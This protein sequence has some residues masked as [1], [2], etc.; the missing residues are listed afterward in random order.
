MH[1]RSSESNQTLSTA[2]TA[3]TPAVAETSAASGPQN[4]EAVFSA[5]VKEQVDA[6]GDVEA[7]KRF[8]IR[9]NQHRK[10]LE[11]HAG[12]ASEEKA[13]KFALRDLTRRGTLTKDQA[14]QIYSRCFQAAQ[15]D[16]NT[17]AL[18]DGVDVPGALTKVIQ[19]ADS[20]L[21]TARTT[22]SALSDGT[23]T[24]TTRSLGESTAK[25]DGT[26]TGGGKKVS[27]AVDGSA[28]GSSDSASPVDGV[29][30]FLFKP[31]SDTQ[32]KLVVV[33]PKE[34][35]GKISKVVLRSMTGEEL[36]SGQYGGV[37]N[38]EREHF[39]Y[40]KP[41]GSYPANLFVEVQLKGGGTKN[42]SIADPSKRYD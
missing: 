34:L 17:G 15:S 1:I 4:E 27:A 33:L 24:L 30:G 18:S 28:A 23:Q 10:I 29:D 12:Y 37:G 3:A 2:G 39:R 42:Y 25:L 31:V 38:G 19:A 22:L 9:I 20:A 11:R 32:G 36:E 35:T 5:L 21:T 13:A 40:N 8:D 14:T 16:G 7:T 26:A 6:I 41:G